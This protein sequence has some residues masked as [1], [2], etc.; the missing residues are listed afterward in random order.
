MPDPSDPGE[1]PATRERMDRFVK[2]LVDHG[3]KPERARELGL[4]E[5]NKYDAGRGVRRQ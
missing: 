4:R 3:T 1:R 5:A 2:H